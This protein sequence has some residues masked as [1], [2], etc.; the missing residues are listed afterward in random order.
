MIYAKAV[1]LLQKLASLSQMKS[2]DGNF[3]FRQSLSTSRMRQSAHNSYAMMATA[4]RAVPNLFGLLSVFFWG[5]LNCSERAVQSC[6]VQFPTS[7]GIFPVL[8]IGAGC[9]TSVATFK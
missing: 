8:G 7:L 1:S 9:G 3:L 5:V 6:T 4:L 2:R